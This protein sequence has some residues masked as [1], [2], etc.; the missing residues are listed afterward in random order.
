MQKT[1]RVYTSD[2]LQTKLWNDDDNFLWT[3]RSVGGA[4]IRFYL[5]S[6]TEPAQEH[7]L[8]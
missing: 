8:L 1:G 2:D 7:Y 5:L 4:L 3:D 6:G